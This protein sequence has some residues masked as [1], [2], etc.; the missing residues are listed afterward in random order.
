MVCIIYVVNLVIKGKVLLSIWFKILTK[1]PS[2]QR[3]KLRVKKKQKYILF[4]VIPM[5]PEWTISFKIWSCLTLCILKVFLRHSFWS[6]IQYMLQLWSLFNFWVIKPP[7]Q[8]S[9]KEL[10]PCETLSHLK[11]TVH[12]LS[13]NKL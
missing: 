10:F 11:S 5:N 4:A 1:L 7:M 3:R 2:F 12:L 9:F 8:S 13:L 6:V